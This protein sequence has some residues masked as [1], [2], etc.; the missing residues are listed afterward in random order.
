MNLV[1]L[2]DPELLIPLDE[3]HSMIQEADKI[4]E[5]EAALWD[6]AKKTK[7]VMHSRDYWKKKIRKAN[8]LVCR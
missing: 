6:R 3:C 8:T 1:K 5:E 4:C 7:I 2:K